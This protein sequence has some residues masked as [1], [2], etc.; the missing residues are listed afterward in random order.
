VKLAFTT[1]R[2]LTIATCATT[3]GAPRAE[4]ATA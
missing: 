2:R 3:S 4:E 1:E